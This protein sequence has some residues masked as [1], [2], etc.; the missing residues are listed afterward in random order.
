MKSERLTTLRNW[1]CLYRLVAIVALLA[2]YPYLL[3]NSWGAI[4][5][6]ALFTAVMLFGLRSVSRSRAQLL[7]M[8]LLLLPAVLGNWIEFDA[9]RRT[10][11]FMLT[12]LTGAF[13]FLLASLVN[14]YGVEI[15]ELSFRMS[16]ASAFIKET[17]WEWRS[18]FVTGPGMRWFY[19]YFACLALLWIGLLLR[20]RSRPWIDALLAFSVTVLSWSPSSM[21]SGIPRKPTRLCFVSAESFSP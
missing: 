20:W 9:E 6:D 15:L 4:L 8:G 3:G 12:A 10:W 19:L 16:E 13:F 14:P 18:P 1:R 17:I 21:V 2:L 11:E 7:G 5:Y